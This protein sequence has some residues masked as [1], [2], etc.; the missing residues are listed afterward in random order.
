MN[1][2]LLIH[3]GLVSGDAELVVEGLLLLAKELVLEVAVLQAGLG[4]TTDIVDVG[5]LLDEHCW[6]GKVLIRFWSARLHPEQAGEKQ[7][8]DS[9]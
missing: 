7:G 8:K 2:G 1:Q 3:R 5:G 6:L 4:D 9:S